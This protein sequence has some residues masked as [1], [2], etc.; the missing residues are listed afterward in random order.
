MAS[1]LNARAIG[2]RPPVNISQT[3]IRMFNTEEPVLLGTTMEERWKSLQTKHNGPDREQSH[4][5]Y[6]D[7]RFWLILL[8]L[9][10]FFAFTLIGFP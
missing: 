4:A 3:E 1:F 7:M 6:R 10:A 8:M 5:F 9:V 2:S